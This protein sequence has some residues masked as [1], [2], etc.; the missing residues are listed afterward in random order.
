M[1]VFNMDNKVMQALDKAADLII[2][3][4]LWALCSLPVITLGASSAALYHA[5]VHTV[6]HGNTHAYRDFLSSF[7]Q[8]F[9]QS[10]PLM[11]PCL[12]ALAFIVLSDLYSWQ[13]SG[14][15]QLLPAVYFVLSMVVR[16]LLLAFMAYAFAMLGRFM[17]PWKTICRLA[18][19]M[20]AQCPLQTI[21]LAAGIYGGF[22]LVTRLYPPLIV[23][24]PG[25]IGYLAAL[26]LEKLFPRYIRFQDP[27]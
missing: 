8:N 27:E 13:G 18:V 14:D 17:L 23:I 25:L 26:L 15:G 16:F 10:L 7:K 11:L 4:V 19:T 20:L 2:L 9:R 1:S 6:M 24:V 12:A 21:L 3:S 22:L 5:L